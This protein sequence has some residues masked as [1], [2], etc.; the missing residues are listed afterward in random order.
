MTPSSRGSPAETVSVTVECAPRLHPVPEYVA[1]ED[2]LRAAGFDPTYRPPVEQRA[3]DTTAV[4]VA[5]YLADRLPG[6]VLDHLAD[7][8]LDWADTHL[9]WL[10]RQRGTTDAVAI[11]IYGPDGEL[12]RQVVVPP[13]DDQQ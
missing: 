2:T 11:P 8:V 4:T 7:A 13:D 3:T 6:R 10:L 12:L 9:R 1:L 5:M